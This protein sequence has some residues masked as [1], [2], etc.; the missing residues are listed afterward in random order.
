MSIS[1]YVSADFFE[2]LEEAGNIVKY[3]EHPAFDA[4]PFLGSIKKHPYDQEKC[5]VLLLQPQ[6]RMPWFKGGEIIELKTRDVQALDELPS[7]IDLTGT[8]ISV[9]RIWVK[10][11]AIAVRFEPFEVTDEE[12]RPFDTDSISRLLAQR[13]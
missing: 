2:T 6:K 4:V 1:N 3:R 11:G 7:A 8:A 5:L 9:F 12:Y 10:R 13:D